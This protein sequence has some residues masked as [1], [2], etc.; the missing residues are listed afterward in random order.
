MALLRLMTRDTDSVGLV[1]NVVVQDEIRTAV[2]AEY[3]VVPDL[4]EN[5]Y[6]ITVPRR[7]APHPLR[8]LLRRSEEEVLGAVAH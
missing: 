2:L 4:F 1:P 8:E 5:F 3:A 7:F 6:G